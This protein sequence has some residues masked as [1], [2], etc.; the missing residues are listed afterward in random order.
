MNFENS[1][2]IYLGIPIVGLL[3][4]F[5]GYKKVDNWVYEKAVRH[6]NWVSHTRGK[7]RI[8]LAIINIVIGLL[9]LALGLMELIWDVFDRPLNG[10]KPTPTERGDTDEKV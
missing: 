2:L 3:V 8:L 10:N 7:G 1:L 9:Q 4:L 5:Y 6:P